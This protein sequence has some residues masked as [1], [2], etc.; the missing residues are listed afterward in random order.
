MKYIKDGLVFINKLDSI[1]DDFI[2]SEITTY[3]KGVIAEL[4]MYH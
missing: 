2:E 3:R 1:Y 4:N